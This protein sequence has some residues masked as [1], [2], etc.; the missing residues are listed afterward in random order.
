MA[1]NILEGESK[2]LAD[3]IGTFFRD[4]DEKMLVTE[5][6]SKR[7]GEE[8]KRVASELLSTR[9]CAEPGAAAL[10]TVRPGF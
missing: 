5:H 2:D 3:F 1:G 6:R 10:H 4:V 8:K 7:T 9:P